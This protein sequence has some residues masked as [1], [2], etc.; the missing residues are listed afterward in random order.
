MLVDRCKSWSGYRV[1]RC[2]TEHGIHLAK[3]ASG[4]SFF[5]E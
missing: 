2:A 3:D 1:M 5:I 4:N